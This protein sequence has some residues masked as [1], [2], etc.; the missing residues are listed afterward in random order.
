[1]IQDSSKILEKVIYLLQ[2]SISP[3]LDD[4]KFQ[5]D[6]NVVELIA[7]G[8]NNAMT[9]LK[10]EPIDMFVFLN[11][12]FAAAQATKIEMSYFDSVENKTKQQT[13]TI[14]LKDAHECGD[15]I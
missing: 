6:S 12:K 2:C 9:I 14:S 1:M 10:N 4:F 5:F 7:P 13:I 11:E 8:T 3:V 15:M